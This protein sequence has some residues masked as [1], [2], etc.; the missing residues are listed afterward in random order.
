MLFAI[1]Y[2]R[3]RT[4]YIGLIIEA[5]IYT[6]PCKG[7]TVFKNKIKSIKAAA[8]FAFTLVVLIFLG[9][10]I[11]M[12]KKDSADGRLLVWKISARIIAEKPTGYGY[13]LF[14]KYYNLKQAEYFK[15][16]KY[17][18]AEKRNAN[19]VNMTYNDYLEQGIEGGIIGMLFLGG[20]YILNICKAFISH[21]PENTAV[22][23]AF[24][25]MSLTNFVYSSILPWLLL[26][27]YA[28]FCNS[29][30]VT[31]ANKSNGK[32]FNR[33]TVTTLSIFAVSFLFLNVIITMA[34]RQLKAIEDTRLLKGIVDDKLYAGIEGKVFTSE[35]FWKSRALNNMAKDD[36]AKAINALHTARQYSSSPELLYMEYNCLMAIGNIDAAIGILTTMSN[37]LPRDLTLKYKLMKFHFSYG[38][39][40]KALFYANDILSTEIKNISTENTTIFQRALKL[41][42][43]YGK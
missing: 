20:F 13:G 43:I 19:F 32:S 2:L 29:V 14:E 42:N 22:V 9:T 11:Y 3:C 26:M 16:G 24:A 36:F 23:V 10:R 34:Q 38:N 21:C 25:V 40:S 5:V 37:M 33:A 15:Q 12:M 31:D 17:S 4:A 8:I 30:C 6:V 18:N 35:A 7:I 28:A 39:K 1:I 27:C 41:K